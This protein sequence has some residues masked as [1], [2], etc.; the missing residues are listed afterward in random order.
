MEVKWPWF[1][2]SREIRNAAALRKSFQVK[3]GDAAA[4]LLSTR[5]ERTATQVFLLN[6]SD[7]RRKNAA[8]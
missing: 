1:K 5:Q 2:F 4:A 3:S 7:K 6:W 8:F